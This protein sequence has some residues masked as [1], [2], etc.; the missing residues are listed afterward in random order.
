MAGGFDPEE[1]AELLNSAIGV[2]CTSHRKRE[3]EKT[4]ISHAERVHSW[5]HQHQAHHAHEQ[6]GGDDG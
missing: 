2:Q 5:M 3:A 6:G 4:D 1:A